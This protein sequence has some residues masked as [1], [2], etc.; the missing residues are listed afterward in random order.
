MNRRDLLLQQMH[1]HQW[2]LQRPDVL[3]GIINMP[4]AEHIRLII[5]AEQEITPQPLFIDILH[6]LNLQISDCLRIDF[7]FVAHLNLQHQVDYWL[8]SDNQEKIDRALSL[9]PQPQHQWQSPAWQ[10]FRQ[11][12]QAKRQLWQQIQKSN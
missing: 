9:C 2:Q 8:L 11:S 6:S 5:I 4:V 1:I 10:T 7:D 12:P 3:K